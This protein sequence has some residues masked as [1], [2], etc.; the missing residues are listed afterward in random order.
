MERSGIDAYVAGQIW[1][2]ADDIPVFIDIGCGFPP[3][4]T[5]D[6]AKK[7]P[8]WHIYGIDRNFARYVV[9]DREGNYACFNRD[10]DFQYFQPQGIKAGRELYANPEKTRLRFN[11]IFADLQPSLSG[12]DDSK[13]VSVEKSGHKLIENH[14]RD[15]ETENLT[16]IESDLE[17]AQ[18]PPARVIRCM[19]A[20]LYFK[21]EIRK[22]M[23]AMLSVLLDDDGIIPP[24]LLVVADLQL[25]IL[26][27]NVKGMKRLTQTNVKVD[28]NPV[29]LK[30]FTT[31][32]QYIKSQITISKFESLMIQT[33]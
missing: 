14:I 3:M 25:Q 10:G 33:F 16:L 11:K 27:Y 24:T 2:A 19:N 30:Q 9:Y 12:D 1:P 6:T 31:I 5:A 7:F 15:F 32:V 21:P 4:T 13:R 20:L 17:T 29:G 26:S 23:I 22:K 28:I 18:L 8:T